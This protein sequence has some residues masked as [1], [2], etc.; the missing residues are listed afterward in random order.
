MRFDEVILRGTRAAQPS[1]LVAPVGALYYVTD[2]NVI[3]RNAGTSW[4]TYSGNASGPSAAV[5][6]KSLARFDGT[7]GRLLKGSLITLTDAGVLGFP[8]NVRQI[9]NPGANAAGLNVG[10][11]A[12]N[13]SALVN[14]DLWYDSTANQMKARANGATLVIGAGDWDATITKTVNEQVANSNSYLEDAELF[15]VL[16]ANGVYLVEAL[17]I[18]SDDTTSGDYKWEWRLGAVLTNAN[19]MDGYWIA[20]GAGPTN[21][22]ATLVSPNS[23]WGNLVI[24]TQ[25]THVPLVMQNRFTI[26]V[27]ATTTSD[28]QLHYR[29]AQ[30]VAGGVGTEAITYAGSFLRYKRLA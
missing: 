7:N 28:F 23:F 4:Q 19:Q 6:D 2:E 27:P 5:T 12:G 11:L 21:E 30:N 14:G 26:V 9:F 8:D 17:I 10:A 24:Q 1:F 3:E 25:A 20:N 22:S 13:P 29:F 15:T 18:L 16:V